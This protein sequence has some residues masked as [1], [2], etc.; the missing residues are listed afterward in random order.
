MGD[1]KEQLAAIRSLV[2]KAQ[3]SDAP[4][5]TPP[6][7]VA[8]ETKARAGEGTPH[9]P[10]GD[11]LLR[12]CL[13][14]LNLLGRIEN[15]DVNRGFGFVATGGRSLFFHV[16]GRLPPST[17][18]VAVDLRNRSVT[19]AV[20]SSEKDGRLCAVQWAL[21]DDIAWPNGQVPQ[22]QSELDDIRT[23][24]FEQQDLPRLLACLPANWYKGF[25]KDSKPSSDLA[26]PVLESAVL[27][28]LRSLSPEEWQVRKIRDV[29]QGGRY[30]FL[31][32]WNW[33]SSPNIGSRSM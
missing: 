3:A 24:W 18:R 11:A 23:K 33:M 7:A 13:E 25:L 17:E 32:K 20:G 5:T 19:Y 10:P 31:R 27:G 26:D 6:L 28:G 14:R 9:P 8:K 1:F 30:S 29:L 12:K 22:S 2:P 4:T 15:F 21:V 16:S